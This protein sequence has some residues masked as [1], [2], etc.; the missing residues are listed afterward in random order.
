MAT[1]ELAPSGESVPVKGPRN[2]S[3]LLFA[4]RRTI[5]PGVHRLFDA[6]DGYLKE[7]PG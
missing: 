7:E 3:S 2:G 4:P 5:R 6:V 1:D